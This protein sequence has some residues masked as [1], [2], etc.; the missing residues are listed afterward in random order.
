MMCNAAVIVFSL[1]KLVGV[2]KRTLEVKL[3]QVNR[4]DARPGVEVNRHQV[5][6]GVP[7]IAQDLRHR[8]ALALVRHWR[9]VQVEVEYLGDV[10][11]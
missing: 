7:L 6:E 5:F 10:L 11:K 8:D 2:G 9:V 3:E 4:F 1:F